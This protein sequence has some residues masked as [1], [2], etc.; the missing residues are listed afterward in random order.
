M[1][2]LRARLT[3]LKTKST[4]LQ[5]LTIFYQVQLLFILFKIKF[6][7]SISQVFILSPKEPNSIV[8][9]VL[10]VVTKWQ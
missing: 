5:A 3:F 10:F 8:T 7:F 9:L 2:I 4:C 6:L 1:L